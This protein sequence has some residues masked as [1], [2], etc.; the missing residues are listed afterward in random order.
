MEAMENMS[1]TTQTV[2]A[3][4]GSSDFSGMLSGKRYYRMEF[5]RKYVFKLP[6]AIDL[7]STSTDILNGKLKGLV[8]FREMKSELREMKNAIGR[9]LFQDFDSFINAEIQ[10]ENTH[11]KARTSC[12]INTKANM[13]TSVFF[14]SRQLW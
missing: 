3:M 12:T 6:G 8:C 5:T 7:L 2:Q 1:K 9:M 11:A 13:L 10:R 14:L 4:L